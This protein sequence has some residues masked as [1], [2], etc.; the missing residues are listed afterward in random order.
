MGSPPSESTS[1]SRGFRTLLTHSQHHKAAVDGTFAVSPPLHVAREVLMA[2]AEEPMNTESK[3]QDDALETRDSHSSST[4]D[5]E[6]GNEEI[7]ELD[8]LDVYEESEP[9]EEDGGLATV[10]LGSETRRRES[11]A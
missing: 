8:L 1:S 2:S 10:V 6:G 3:V 7:L 9:E 11:A 5:E 4:G